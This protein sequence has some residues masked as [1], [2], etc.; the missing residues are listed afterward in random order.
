VLQQYAPR[1]PTQSAFYGSAVARLDDLVAARRDRLQ[2]AAQALPG[3]FEILIFGGAFAV[4]CLLWFFAIPSLR[5][6][7]ALVAVVAGL[8]G[9]NLLISALLD[10]PFS[11]D[12]SVST[13]PYEAVRELRPS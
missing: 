6:Q 3:P 2:H 7:I 9:F 4:T 5:M 1:G 12:F 10:H 11:G 8:I 13:A